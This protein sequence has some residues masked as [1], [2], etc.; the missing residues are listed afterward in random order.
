MI[1]VLANDT[2]H[3]RYGVITSKKIGK[4][5]ARNRVRRLFQEAIRL[6]HP[7][8][9]QGYDVVFVA[10]PAC[11]GQGLAAICDAVRVL[12]RQAGLID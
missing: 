1:S 3:N 9:R 11:V 10:H 8:L 5:V 2:G 12:Y 6:Y 7:R 4:A